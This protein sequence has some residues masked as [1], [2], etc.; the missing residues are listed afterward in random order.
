MSGTYGGYLEQT[1]VI[2]KRVEQLT[3]EKRELLSK[4]LEENKE[5][6][7]VSQKLILSEREVRTLK[8]KVTKMTLEKERGERRAANQ[9]AS[10]LIDLSSPVKPN[11]IDG[12]VGKKRLSSDIANQEN[13]H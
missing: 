8:A 1:E 7:E 11:G 10:E 6:I 13:I 4:N 9:A 3:R 12:I 2:D 5:R